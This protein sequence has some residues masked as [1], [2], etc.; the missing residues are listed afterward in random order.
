MEYDVKAVEEK[1][2]K[3]WDEHGLYRFDPVEVDPER[4]CYCLVMF[5]Y[6]SSDKL[7]IGHWYNFA[8]VD[9][10]AR[11]R[12]MRGWQVF[13]PMGFDAFG[14]PAEN[15]A[16]KTGIHPRESTMANI[17]YMEEQLKRI[18][19][20]YDW[21]YEII[22]CEPGYYRWTQ[23][24]FLKLYEKGL[25]Y[26]ANAPVNWCPSCNTVLANEQVQ[27]GECERCH[28]PV[29]RRN[30]T[31]WFFRITAYAERLL[32]NLDGLDWPEK[33]KAMQRNW[34]GRSEG[35]DI[36][37]ELD[38]GRGVEVFT[39][40]PDTLMGVTYLVLAP[41]HPLV[42]EITTSEHRGEVDEYRD[43][44]LKESEMERLST[45]REKTG[46]FTGAYA[47]HPVTGERVPVWIA[48][49]V[50][51]GYGRGAVMAVP[52][53][54]ERDF[55]FARKY[56][57]PVRKVIL[58][59]GDE[60][61]RPLD[62]AY[63]GPGRMVNSGPFDGLDS[64]AGKKA[65]VEWLERHG[66]GKA[67]V[68]YR[69]RD[70]LVSRQ[71]YWGAP[72]PMVHCPDC[73]EVP[74]PEEDLP[75]ELPYDVDFKPTG[76]SPL[77]S[78]RE[79]LETTCP[80]CGSK[81]RREAD[82]MD[83]F[84]CS[85][86][87]FLRYP[88]ARMHDRPFD[89]ELLSRICPVDKYVGGPEHACMHLLYARF[90]NMALYDMGLIDFEEPFTS[91]VHQGII[92]GPDGMRMSKSR[93]NVVQPDDYVER[94]G[95]D[96]FRCYLMF[97]FD[98]TVGGA[99]DDSGIRAMEKFFDR[100]YRLYRDMAPLFL[101]RKRRGEVAGPRSDM[102]KAD[103]EL[104]RAR[105]HAIKHVTADTER[106][107]FNTSISRMME[108]VNAVYRYVQKVPRPE[109]DEALLIS[110]LEDLNRLLAPFA[111]HLAEEL[112]SMCGH[113]R[114][115]FL[116]S[117]PS[118]SEEALRTEKIRMA[119][120]VNGKVRAQLEVDADADD[121]TIKKAAL[122]CGRVPSYVEGREIVKIVLVRGRLVNIVVK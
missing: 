103:R 1:W 68:T 38:G 10:W 17:R 14:L 29:T 34:I 58:A 36:V 56:G 104:E 98:Y 90:V 66:M 95:S 100:V 20:M 42:D 11:F 21:D 47:L 74:V 110:V 76:E 24:I 2:R 96:V 93:G 67:T 33:T 26:R 7:H 39:T 119:V 82:T 59:P 15:Y 94:Y 32:K 89:K 55:E 22:T 3:Y 63:T 91:L 99:W 109:R 23:W 41:E 83:T 46:V 57:L 54:D 107:H 92:L 73:G 79:F 72:I 52:A 113:E 81:A 70:W 64:E 62:E 65:V 18:G 87:Y 28:T 16:V 88:C 35:A 122:E 106:F 44:V 108:L 69:L 111:P 43:R 84:V 114:S 120:Q 6:P 115:V 77:A 48:D 117:W 27:G 8:P 101:D 30:L 50:L 112:W 19:A 40:R 25:A 5:S 61:D 118:W 105:H 9:T 45:V 31:Q 102:R 97:G 37:F 49:Y 75:V 86:W 80:R 12:R 53:H 85:S 60:V 78:C 71:R 121:E 51:Y 4:K 116:E 13:E